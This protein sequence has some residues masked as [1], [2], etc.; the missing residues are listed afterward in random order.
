M[1]V[2][3]K[4][5]RS[6]EV[7]KNSSCMCAGSVHTARVLASATFFGVRPMSCHRDAWWLFYIILVYGKQV[8]QVV[9]VYL[10][11]L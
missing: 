6:E 8:R 1:H 7:E 4:Y 3:Q 2:A 5:K 11:N 10:I 9:A